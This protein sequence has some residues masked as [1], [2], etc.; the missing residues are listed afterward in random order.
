MVLQEKE[1]VQDVQFKTIYRV[2][3]CVLKRGESS[4]K[5]VQKDMLFTTP[6]QARYHLKRLVE[7]GLI[8]QA[9]NG[10]FKVAKKKFGILRFFFKIRN[11][12]VPMSLFYAGFFAVCTVLFYLRNP[13]I[14]LLLLGVLITAKETA[15]TYSYF[16]ML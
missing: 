15:D 8:I 12:V 13:S 16:A 11:S 14:E 4:I 5:D 10:N 9:D 3:L 6:A 7:L 2:Y 1:F